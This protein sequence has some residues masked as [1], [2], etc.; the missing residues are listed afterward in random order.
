MVDASFPRKWR[1]LATGSLYDS[2][3]APYD[4]VNEGA[5]IPFQTRRG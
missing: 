1:H 4:M 2:L 5:H 3:V